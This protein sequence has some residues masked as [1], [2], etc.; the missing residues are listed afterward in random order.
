MEE[1]VV[2]ELTVLAKDPQAPVEQPSDLQAQQSARGAHNP[3]PPGKPPPGS[4]TEI[5][6]GC[7]EAGLPFAPATGTPTP[8]DADGR[9]PPGTW[10]AVTGE[11]KP[12][13]WLAASAAVASS[14][15]PSAIAATSG[16]RRGGRS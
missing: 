6:S 15:A 3:H 9:S 5:A 8:L 16:T 10:V 11:P 4:A 14:S 13:I 2:V 1:P 7:T 12:M